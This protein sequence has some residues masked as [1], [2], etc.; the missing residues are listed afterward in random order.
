M[1]RL[2]RSVLIN[3][4][5]ILD[6][7]NLLLYIIDIKLIITHTRVYKVIKVYVL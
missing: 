7:K 1:F 6:N 2:S 5:I 4:N 3:F